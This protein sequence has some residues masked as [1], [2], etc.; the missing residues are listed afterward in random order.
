M[1]LKNG[2]EYSDW[3]GA[4]QENGE[5]IAHQKSSVVAEETAVDERRV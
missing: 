3:G 1:Q 2:E 5:Q 4:C